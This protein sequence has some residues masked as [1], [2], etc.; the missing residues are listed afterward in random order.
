MPRKLLALLVVAFLLAPTLTG[1]FDV[2]EIDDEVYAISVGVDKGTTSKVRLTIQ[3]PNYK[4]GGGDSGSSEKDPASVSSKNDQES[5]SVQTM[6]APTMLE[7]VDMFSMAISRKVS[8]IHAKWFIF[9]EEFAREGIEGYI[10]GLE[11]FRETRASTAVLITRGKAEDFIRENRPS[12][13][14]NISKSVEL[15]L[16]QSKATGFFPDIRFIDF[17]TALFSSYRSPVALYGGVNDLQESS[18][19]KNGSESLTGRKNVLPGE[20]PRSGISKRELIG[21]SVFDGGQM[22]GSLGPYETAGYLMITGLYKGGRISIPDR[23]KPE[24]AIVFDLHN[25]RS[26]KIKAYFKDGKPVVDVKIAMES[27]I[28]VIQSR[29]DYEDLSHQNELGDQITEYIQNCL[30]ATVR[31]T[32]KELHTDIFGFGE[33][34]AGNFSTIEEWENYNWL[35][36]YSE[37]EINVSADVKVRRTGLIFH[38]SPV[39]SSKGRGE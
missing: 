12:T 30:N 5:S 16:A 32:Q 31:K 39:F 29:I 11:R 38:S 18:I 27:E 23:Y 1:C 35:S 21:L 9:S 19:P 3:Y 2:H 15:F 25:S 22:V 10:A 6:E 26:P 24:D 28:Y 37:A 36:H 4:S 8:L 33:W 20:L 14:E 17:Y 34:M 13:G 7:A